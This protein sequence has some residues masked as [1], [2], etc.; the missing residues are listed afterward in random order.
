[1]PKP[2]ED[3]CMKYICA[4]LI[5]MTLCS[6]FA[7][8]T[9]SRSDS[10][11][12]SEVENNRTI[13]QPFSRF[14]GGDEF[15]HVNDLSSLLAY[16]DDTPIRALG[17]RFGTFSDLSPL[18][19][20][21]E[22][23][24]LDIRFN[25]NITDLSPLGSLV[26][27]QRL[28]LNQRF[29]GSIEPLSLLVNLQ[30]LNLVYVNS[31][32]RELLP[33]QNL[34]TLILS[35]RGEGCLDVTYI[36]QLRSLRVLDISSRSINNIGLLGNLVNLEKLVIRGDGR[37][38]LSWVRSLQNIKY[39]ELYGTA[40]ECINVLAELSNLVEVHLFNSVLSD[41]TP[42]LESRSIQ[43]I[44]QYHDELPT[45]DVYYEAIRLQNLFK[46]QSINFSRIFS[47]R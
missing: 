7:S 30:Y 13:Q 2:V 18:S 33:L 37:I 45:D 35:E 40:I 41:P 44:V 15:L 5:A 3:S 24:D 46:E 42:L 12:V 6:C 32:Y 8:R 29:V 27:L 14:I 47:D 22:L 43:I 36:S 20:L 17:F 38:D 10:I 4:I 39:L 9:D 25:D 19:A 1:M 16:L 34:E 21:T 26:S 28:A 23:V 11:E 31:N